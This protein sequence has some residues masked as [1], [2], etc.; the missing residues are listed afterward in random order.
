MRPMM[1][2]PEIT[3]VS[4]PP[5]GRRRLTPVGPA[6]RVVVVGNGMVGWRLCQELVA[7]GVNESATISVFGEEARPAYDRVHLTSLFSGHPVDDLMLSPREWYADNRIALVTGDPVVA[8]DRERKTITTRRGLIATYDWL[9]L[10]TGSRP[11]VPPMRGTKVPGVFVYRTIEDI[12]AIRAR[13]QGAKSAAVIGGGLLGLEAAQA[14]LNLGLAATV[15]ERGPGLMARQLSPAAADL[16]RRKVEEL[17][18]RVLLKSETLEARPREAG[19]LSIILRDYDSLDCDLLIVA[20]GIRPRQELAEACG[21]PCDRRGGVVVDDRLTTADPQILAIGECAAH[22]GIV[23]G[24]A[25]PGFLMAEVAAARLAGRDA[26]FTG[27]PLSARLKLL[28]I[29]VAALGEFQDDGDS[30]RHVTPATHRELI[31][32]RGRLIGVR[33]AGLLG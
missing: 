26:T 22:R 17:G 13:A 27:T 21:L 3:R 1:P 33:P 12:E 24:L 6:S 14:L 11:F 29:E 16:L 28:G 8:I 10:A 5:R 18:V 23:Y 31:F 19:G 2:V 15:I 25:A 4:R 32:R 30:F 7:A 9:V 20:A